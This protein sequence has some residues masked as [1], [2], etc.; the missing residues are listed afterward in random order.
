ML[1]TRHCKINITV[2]TFKLTNNQQC[3]IYK[4]AVIHVECRAKSQYIFY[5]FTNIMSHLALR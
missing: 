2:R 5:Y 4:L 3:E 1:Q